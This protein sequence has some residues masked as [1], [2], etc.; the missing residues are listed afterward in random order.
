MQRQYLSLTAN[1]EA[2]KLYGDEPAFK[3]IQLVGDD[4]ANAL[5]IV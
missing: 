2:M 5:S 1:S 4:G 3:F